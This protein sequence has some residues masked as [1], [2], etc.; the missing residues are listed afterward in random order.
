MQD[1]FIKGHH[2]VD[3]FLLA[4]E[5]F[6]SMN[7]SKNKIGWII[8]KIDI[9]KDFDT[10]SWTF[11]LKILE[12]FNL[13]TQWISLIKSCLCQM[14]YT[15]LLNGSKHESFKPSRGIRQGDPLSP[16]LFILAMD[17]LT[18]LITNAISL[19]TWK[20]FKLKSKF[21]CFS[22]ALCR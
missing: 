10:I 14:D 4:H 16:Y 20:P 6:H 17:C 11:I 21:P 15:P 5:T 22:L 1:A 19:K 8:L 3:L 13:P 7:I 9:R 18:T 12:A 2:T